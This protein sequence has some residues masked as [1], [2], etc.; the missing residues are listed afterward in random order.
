MNSVDKDIGNNREI[1]HTDIFSQWQGLII[2]NEFSV[3]VRI[4]DHDKFSSHTTYNFNW[5]RDLS[6]NLRVN[7]SY[8]T[9][10][11]L[12]NHWSNNAAIVAGAS[13]LKPERSKNIEFGLTSNNEWGSAELKLYKSKLNDAFVWCNCSPGYY[14]NGGTLNIEGVEISFGTDIRGWNLNTNLD[15]VKAID[16]SSKKDQGRRPKRSISLNLSKTSGKW[17]RNINWTAKSRT[18]DTDSETSRLGGYGI[19]NLSTSY[20]FNEDL[21][22]YFNRSNVLDKNYEMAK[23]YNTLGKTSTLGLTYTF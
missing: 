6:A 22:V 5:A 2:D 4:I 9:A 7:G 15:F 10:T 12:P 18:W 21:T 20:D 23:G 1:K 13:S 17:K 8:G 3:G 19:L 16:A 14:S 11:N